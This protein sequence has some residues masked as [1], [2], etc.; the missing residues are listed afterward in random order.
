MGSRAGSA[1]DK[2]WKGASASLSPRAHRGAGV[3]LGAGAEERLDAVAVS[4]ERC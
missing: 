3:R 2:L 4:V 1:R